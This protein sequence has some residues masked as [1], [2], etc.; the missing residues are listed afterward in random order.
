M[1]VTIDGIKYFIKQTDCKKT[2][3][4]QLRHLLVKYVAK[5]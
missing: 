1:I 2:E 4:N 5:L 3:Q